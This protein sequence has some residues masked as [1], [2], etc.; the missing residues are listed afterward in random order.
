MGNND[1]YV[2]N[3]RPYPH[4]KQSSILYLWEHLYE[5]Y[6]GV[7]IPLEKNANL[8]VNKIQF[9]NQFSLSLDLFYV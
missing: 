1:Y 6:Y 4:I 8:K 2:S 5:V 3:M 7:S 9:E